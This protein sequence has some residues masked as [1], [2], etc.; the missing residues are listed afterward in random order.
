MPLKRHERL[1]ERVTGRTLY[2]SSGSCLNRSTGLLVRFMGTGQSVA[3]K[4]EN[5]R[6]PRKL[7]CP[8]GLRLRLCPL[9]ERFK[10]EVCKVNVR[11][12][13]PLDRF[14]Q[15]RSANLCVS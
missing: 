9:L 6:S 2:P 5:V 12:R 8:R 1:S 10:V 4:S 14:K 15:R 13:Q 7:L 11:V 3:K